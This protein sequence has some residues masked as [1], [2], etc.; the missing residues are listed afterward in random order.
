MLVFY[1]WPFPHVYLAKNVT[2]FPF[3]SWLSFQRLC[4]LLWG[5]HFHLS[6]ASCFKYFC[7]SC[8]FL[9][10][11]LI[12][13]SKTSATAMMYRPI[14]NRQTVSFSCRH[15]E[16]LGMS[17]LSCKPLKQLYKTIKLL[18]SHY[19]SQAFNICR[20]LYFSRCFSTQLTFVMHLWSRFFQ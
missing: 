2:Y 19:F 5:Y 18:K 1:D 15:L 12:L 11:V 20:F 6:T 16:V 8:P 4:R 13:V 10:R 17:I 7:D 3:N 9:A 14:F